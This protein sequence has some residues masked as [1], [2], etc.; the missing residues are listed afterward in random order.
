MEINPKHFIMSELKKMVATNKS[1]EIVKDMI[2]LLPDIFLHNS[3]FNIDEFTHIASCTNCEINLKHYIMSELK[4]TVATNK[5]GKIV[6]DML[7]LL[8]DA[9]LVAS[10]M[11]EVE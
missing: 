11:K 6:K 3:G 5:S 8:L 2:W 10:N 1:D 9:V 7:L 4:E